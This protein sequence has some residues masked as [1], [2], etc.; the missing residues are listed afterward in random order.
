MRQQLRSLTAQE[1]AQAAMIT[2]QEG[3]AP[4]AFGVTGARALRAAC[5][6]G[7]LLHMIGGVLGMAVVLVLLVLG[8]MELLTPANMFLYQLVWIIPGWLATEWTR[9]I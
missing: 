1:E 3:L 9:S 7:V 2:T 8:Y 5:N 4:M 6:F